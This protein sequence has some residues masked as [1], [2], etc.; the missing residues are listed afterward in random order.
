MKVILKDSL[1]IL[2]PETEAERAELEAWKAGCAGHVFAPGG[3]GKGM[4]L[5]DLG[6]REEACNEPLQVSSRSASPEGRLISNF[7]A[8]PFELDGA[9][10][11]SVE[12][13]WQGLKF[14]SAAERKAVADLEGPAAQR[15]GQRQGYG[16]HV[17]YQGRLI[18][19]GAWEH[20]QLME[21]AC[22]AKFTQNAEAR[23]A[24]LATGSRPLVHRMRRD[25]RTIPGALM[26]DIW[27]RIRGKLQ[28]KG[29]AT[30][31]P[32]EVE[33]DPSEAAAVGGA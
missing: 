19:V 26:A 3:K 22:W 6:P 8:A 18:P 30:A 20:W 15:A 27:M 12:S 16:S 13:F 31:L 17:T 2:S 24:L 21:R 7:A 9:T 23:A 4:A 1:L 14:D 25:S 29:P 5:R 11:Q 28:G 33:E 10:Y 32:H